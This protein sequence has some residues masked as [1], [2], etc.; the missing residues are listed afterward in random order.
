MSRA[1]LSTPRGVTAKRFVRNYLSTL[2]F[3][4]LG[5]YVC[6]ELSAF[7]RDTLSASVNFSLLNWTGTL[8]ARALFIGLLAVFAAALIPY[9]LK[10]PWVSAKAWVFARGVW[11]GLHRRPSLRVSSK[12][13]RRYGL[14]TDDKPR[15]TTA[16]TQAG[17]TLLLKFFF[18]PLMINWCLAHIGDM[19]HNTRLVWSDIQAGY[20]LRALFDH[21]LFWALFQ[22][23]LFVDTLLFTL[24]YLVE[25]PRLRNR[26]VSV[27][28]TFLG[29]F[30][31]LACYPPFNGHTG[32]F[33][34]WQSTD[35]PSFSNDTVHLFLN[36]C[37]LGLMA[38][39]SWASIA[40]GF[41]A[42]NLT[43][44]GIVCSGPYA[45]VRHPAYVAKNAAWWIGAL[46]AFYS[47]FGGGIRAGLYAIACTAG[48]SFIYYMRAITEE[49]HLLRANNGYAEYMRSVRWRFIPG[50]A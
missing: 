15:L 25:V 38:L 43:N 11:L 4:V 1:P 33:L 29:W 16:T 37:I 30:V 19:L 47:A 7:H 41:K 17:L 12:K 31:C 46:P 23:I 9:Y 20:A 27:E 26:I 18:A 50:I 6:F 14:R 13:I 8:S 48:W 22:L 40:L 5:W 39:Y 28:P 49:R 34:T 42:S 35:F 10:H 45:F 21:A 36:G 2:L 44:R 3:L 32:A 24:G